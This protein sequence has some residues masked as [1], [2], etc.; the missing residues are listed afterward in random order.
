ME[1]G[2]PLFKK[3]GHG[4]TSVTPK[5]RIEAVVFSFLFLLLRFEQNDFIQKLLFAQIAFAFMTSR[6][7]PSVVA[8]GKR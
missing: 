2:V 7:K 5:W 1:E 6:D 4:H 3:L 8:L